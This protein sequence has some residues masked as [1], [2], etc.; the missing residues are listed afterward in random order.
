MAVA[1]EDAAASRNLTDSLAEFDN[2]TGGD[3]ADDFMSSFADIETLVVDEPAPTQ[4]PAAPAKPD[5]TSEDDLDDLFPSGDDPDAPKPGDDTPAPT[6]PKA[7]EDEFANPPGKT[8]KGVREHW[9]KL[10]DARRDALQKAEALEAEKTKLQQEAE[11]LRRQLADLPTYK[12]K[13]Q[14]AEDAEKELALSR[15]EGS[16]EFKVAVRDPLAAIEAN[17]I[18]VAE[19]NNIPQDDLI[20]AL[21]EPDAAKRRIALSNILSG[22]E[23]Y[24]KQEIIQMA[25]DTQTVLAKA[26]A[27]RQNASEAR[28]ELERKQ[29]ETLEKETAQLRSDHESRVDKTLGELRKRVPFVALKDGETADGVFQTVLDA[30][31]KADLD[32]NPN[33]RAFAATAAVLLPRVNAQLVAVSKERDQLKARVAEL[34]ASRPGLTGSAHAA[35]TNEDDDDESSLSGD[36]FARSMMKGIR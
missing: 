10:R 18:R 28:A 15:V 6:K 12:E 7:G 35:P 14:F 11:D 9:D 1:A 20:D 31:R 29:A 8:S 17:A 25:R 27:M 13:A 24:D 26:A 3:P 32:A 34:T 36:A 2:P 5:T 21:S 22:L 33:N 4:T 30:A 19:A 23:E 16:R